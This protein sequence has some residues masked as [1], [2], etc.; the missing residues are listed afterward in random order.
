MASDDG[1]LLPEE[2]DG[3]ELD[4][5]PADASDLFDPAAL[6][7]PEKRA[8]LSALLFSAGEALPAERLGEFLGL[9]AA[10][11]ALLVE[12]ASGE[13]RAL[14]L[15]ILGA[16]G[17]FRMV[18]T[19]RWDAYLARFHR[20]VRRAKLSKSALEILAVI[21]YEQP[22]SRVRVDA[23]RQVNS[24][25]TLRALLD[26]HLITV[27]GRADTP[28]RPF[29]YRTTAKFLEVFGLATLDDLPPRPASLDLAPSG[30]EEGAESGQTPSLDDLPGFDDDTL[31]P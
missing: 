4:G 28:G 2:L 6:S 22:V 1:E 25:S 21:A 11:L 27:A 14:G 17:G 10:A 8:L 18:T 29:L 3:P 5:Q 15:D 7:A 31:E 20:Q 16:A 23:L 30:E 26:K 24:E 9:D 19:G 12:E 13:L